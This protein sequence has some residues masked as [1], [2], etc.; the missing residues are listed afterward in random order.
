MPRDHGKTV[1]SM[2]EALGPVTKVAGP[3][4][5]WGK[6]LYVNMPRQNLTLRRLFPPKVAASETSVLLVA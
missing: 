1:A 2:Y 4:S 5:R 3:Y 6:E